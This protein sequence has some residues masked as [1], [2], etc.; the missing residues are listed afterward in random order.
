MDTFSRHTWCY[1]MVDKH[2][3]SVPFLVQKSTLT[4]CLSNILLSFFL[5][6]LDANWI[7]LLSKNNDLCLK[8]KILSHF[9]CE[10]THSLKAVISLPADEHNELFWRVCVISKRKRLSSSGSIKV[11][12]PWP[13]L[14]SDILHIRQRRTW[15]TQINEPDW[16]HLEA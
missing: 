3:P 6:I 5:P 16:K 4:W 14:L 12:P 2:C 13:W 11:L 7:K 9:Q 1:L 10:C 8:K 15:K